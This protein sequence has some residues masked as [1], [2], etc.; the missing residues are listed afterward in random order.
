MHFLCHFYF[1]TCKLKHDC[2]DLRQYS[3]YYINNSPNN[4]CHVIITNFEARNT[5]L[6]FP[7]FHFHSHFLK[8]P[9]NLAKNWDAF[10]SNAVRLAPSSYVAGM[11]VKCAEWGTGF[12]LNLMSCERPGLVCSI[13]SSLQLSSFLVSHL[14]FARPIFNIQGM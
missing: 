14:G 3:T 6:I 9:S 4:L 5:V 2:L 10:F 12:P 11:V 13:H 8:R 1:M 7:N